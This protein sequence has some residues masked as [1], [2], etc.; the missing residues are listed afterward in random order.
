[1]SLIL[2][3]C[4]IAPCVFVWLLA[5]QPPDL[6]AAEW[7]LSPS[8]EVGGEYNSS[9][10][11]G[12]GREIE[13]FVTRGKPRVEILAATE[14]NRLLLD[15]GLTGEKYIKNG[16]LDT[17]DSENRAS[18]TRYWTPAF[19]TQLGG[20]FSKDTT[21]ETEL[22][23]AGLRADRRDRYR[24]GGD[25]GGTLL[26]SDTANVALSGAFSANRYPEGD[27]PDYRQWQVGL[28]PALKINPRDTVGVAVYHSDSDYEDT[29]RVRAVSGTVYW[30]RNW[31]ETDSLT[32]G[33][34][35]YYSWLDLRAL[36]I[37]GLPR[38]PD[39]EETEGGFLVDIALNR[40]W[41]ERLSTTVSAGRQQ[42]DSVDAGTVERTYVRTS[43]SYLL[44][45]LLAL[46]LNLGWDYHTQVG[47]SGQDSYYLRAL[48]SL[49]WQIGKDTFLT[50][51]AGYE[52]VERQGGGEGDT[53]RYRGWVTLLRRWPNLL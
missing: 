29:G 17:V 48:P 32:V 19:S 40:A 50:W 47:D 53:E 35:Y 44:T 5:C 13:D 6:R 41:T 39:Q 24:F 30:R 51:G 22:E 4:V 46:L 37:P 31:T 42:Y 1:M 28:D 21:L 34:G 2:R 10:L 27:Y 7:S 20:T 11:L 43:A 3:S 15:A 25:L 9:V 8:L 18:W 16:G 33:A 36:T 12:S 23:A 49:R 52:R 38:P 26:L 45:P 14:R